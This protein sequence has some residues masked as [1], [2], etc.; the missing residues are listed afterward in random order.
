MNDANGRRIRSS[1]AIAACSATNNGTKL[2]RC[3]SLPAQKQRSV[4]YMSSKETANLKLQLESS[5]ESLGEYGHIIIC[6]NVCVFAR[7]VQSIGIVY[8][9]YGI[10]LCWTHTRV[11][12]CYCL[13]GLSACLFN[14]L[15][16]CLSVSWF[17][18]FFSLLFLLFACACV[19]ACD[20]VLESAVTS[21]DCVIM[22]I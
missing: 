1:N 15:S 20:C 10:P 9:Y 21:K 13:P 5:V 12:V 14:C 11:R 6:I 2:K 8:H 4:P 18:L 3:A 19:S 16:T 17:V 22:I 7:T